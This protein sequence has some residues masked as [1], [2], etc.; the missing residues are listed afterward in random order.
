M[1]VVMVKHTSNGKVFWFEVPDNLV[2]KITVGTNVICNT[3]Y[4]K[5]N[6]MAISTPLDSE[7]VKCVMAASGAVYPLRKIAGIGHKIPLEAITVP[8][9]MLKSHPSDEKIAKRFMEVYHTGT[10]HTNIAVDKDYN[11]LDGYTAY[12]VA[13]RL[14]WSNI[15]AVVQ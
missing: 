1:N 2:N 15:T 14:G 5:R 13:K 7:E 8:N 10:F 3:A 9:Y 12:L 11:L 4:G 6:G